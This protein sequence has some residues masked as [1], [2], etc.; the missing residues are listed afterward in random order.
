MH[1]A[2]ATHTNAFQ[3]QI[4]NALFQRYWLT[5]HITLLSIFLDQTA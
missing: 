4:P 1:H 5:V 2:Y 3:R